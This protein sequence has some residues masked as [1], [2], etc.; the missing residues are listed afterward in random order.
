MH[1]T[2]LQAM[3]LCKPT[4]YGCT[5]RAAANYE[6]TG[7]TPPCIKDAT[8]VCIFDPEPCFCGCFFDVPGC[9]F[10]VALNYLPTSTKDDPNPPYKCIAAGFALFPAPSP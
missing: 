7:T 2:P 8:D 5:L 10:S 4:I 6:S 3:L 9:T 1:H